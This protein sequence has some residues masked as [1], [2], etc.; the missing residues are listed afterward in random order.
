MIF[1][2]RPEGKSPGRNRQAC[3]LRYGNALGR[4]DFWAP[5]GKNAAKI[6]KNIGILRILPGS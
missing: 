3:S 2:F 5:F 6:R 1:L 4:F